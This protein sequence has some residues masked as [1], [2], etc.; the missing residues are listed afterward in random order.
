[1][2]SKYSRSKKHHSP[3]TTRHQVVLGLIYLG[4]ATI[5]ARLFYWQMLQSSGLK[6]AANNQYHRTTTQT[7][8][9]GQIFTSDGKLLVGNTFEY[10]LVAYPQLLTDSPQK[11][12]QL[13]QPILLEEYEPFLEATKSSKKETIADDLALNLENKLRKK[14][15]KWISLMTNLTEEV[16]E[17]ISALEI[18]G[19]DFESSPTR[20]YPE[21]SMAAQLTG[22]VAQDENGQSVGYF[23]VEGALNKEFGRKEKKNHHHYRCSRFIFSRPK[24]RISLC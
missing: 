18:P 2:I 17:K 22:F 1:M 20:F 6:T 7:G 10:R 13:I 12:T 19:L 24:R 14:E 5:L 11:I 21:A 16:K 3:S 4:L 23:G 9:R 15:A 8:N